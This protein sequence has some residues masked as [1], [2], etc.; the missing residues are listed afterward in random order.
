MGRVLDIDST[1]PKMGR[2]TDMG[3]Q[4]TQWGTQ[5]KTIFEALP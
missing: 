4:K 5:M 3:G 2:W 1:G